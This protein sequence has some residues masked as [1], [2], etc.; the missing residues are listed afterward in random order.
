MRPKSIVTFERL[1]LLSLAIALIVSV[2]TWRE[3][4][5]AAEASGLGSSFLWISYAAGFGLGLLLILLISRKASSIAKWVLVVLTAIGV[6]GMLTRVG[7]LLGGGAAGFAELAQVV[8]LVVSLT[9]LFR[10]DAKAWFA[11]GDDGRDAAA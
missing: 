10:D 5:A 1:A 4:L 9:F 7:D 2:V 11:R 8:I 6:V 3:S